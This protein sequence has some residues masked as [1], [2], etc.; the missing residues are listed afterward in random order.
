MLL[1]VFLSLH[2]P[3]AFRPFICESS[4]LKHFSEFL[5]RPIYLVLVAHPELNPVAEI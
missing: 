5:H 2:L 3:H 1:S 4:L